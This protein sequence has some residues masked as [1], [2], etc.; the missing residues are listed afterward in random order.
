[1]LTLVFVFSCCP[2]CVAGSAIITMVGIHILTQRKPSPSKDSPSVGDVE[3]TEGGSY[4][5]N[6][7]A[8]GV[9][10]LAPPR[11]ESLVRSRARSIDFSVG[12]ASLMATPMPAVADDDAMAFSIMEAAAVTV[13]PD[14]KPRL[15]SLSENEALP[16]ESPLP[17]PSPSLP[18][19]SPSPPKRS[20]LQGLLNM[21]P[22]AAASHGTHGSGDMSAAMLSGEGTVDDGVLVLPHTAAAAA[23][24]VRSDGDSAVASSHSSARTSPALTGRKV[25]SPS[26]GSVCVS[27]PGSPARDSASHY[28]EL[29][30]PAAVVPSHDSSTH[31]LS[32]SL[33]PRGSFTGTGATSSPPAAAVAAAAAAAAATATPGAQ[34]TDDDTADFNPF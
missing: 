13:S 19:T 5:A 27:V 29:L 15:S 20:L 30:S 31:V 32:T 4:T 6:P 33:R 14:A 28:H 34:P 10:P 8:T 1:M 2:R 18:S 12:F 23:P 11:R 24:P 26:S 7:L 22:S 16:D 21:L 25:G 3:M 17:A 9:S